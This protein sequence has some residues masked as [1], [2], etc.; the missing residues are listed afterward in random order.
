M[1]SAY[2]VYYGYNVITYV[3]TSRRRGAVNI[4]RFI[5][6]RTSARRESYV[7]RRDRRLLHVFDVHR[8]R[9][10]CTARFPRGLSR[11]KFATKTLSSFPRLSRRRVCIHRNH[12]VRRSYAIATR[13]TAVH[14]SVQA[15]QYVNGTRTKRKTAAAFR[16]CAPL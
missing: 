15:T 5:A 14:N 7:F 9:R 12:V 1:L 11:F 8:S 2:V 6:C 10:D 4:I 13:A 3:L 16:H